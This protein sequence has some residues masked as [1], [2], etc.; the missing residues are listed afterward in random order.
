VGKRGWRG[1][2][3]WPKHLA[4]L[5]A[6]LLKRRYISQFFIAAAKYLKKKTAYKEERFILA[7]GVRSFSPQSLGSVV[8]R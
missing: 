2:A 6:V 8:V 3:A 7:H 4:L 1:C 5:F